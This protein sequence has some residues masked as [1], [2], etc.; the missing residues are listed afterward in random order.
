MMVKDLRRVA[1]RA[2]S[3]WIAYLGILWGVAMQ[4]PELATH[5]QAV[6]DAI[7]IGAQGAKWIAIGSA[8]AA[9]ARVIGQG[10]KNG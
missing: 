6:A 5:F 3:M 4:F 8:I 2:Y 10:Q 7:G 9:L 1:T